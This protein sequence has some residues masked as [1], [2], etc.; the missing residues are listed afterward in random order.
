VN[1][2]EFGFVA[3]IRGQRSLRLAGEGAR[4]VG[5]R[6]GGDVDVQSAF[7]EQEDLGGAGG[8]ADRIEQVVAVDLLEHVPGRA[9]HDRLDESVRSRP[10]ADDSH[11]RAHQCISVG[12]RW[13]FALGQ[14]N[15]EG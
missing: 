6:G 2:A 3:G 5:R 8:V 13:G 7:G 12:P 1:D 9:G 4:E 10:G 15:G 14:K 11:L